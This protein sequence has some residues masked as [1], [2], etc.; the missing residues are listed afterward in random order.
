MPP[1]KATKTKKPKKVLKPKKASKHRKVTKLK[2]LTSKEERARAKLAA[3]DPSNPMLSLRPS[4]HIVGLK[5]LLAL[6]KDMIVR[7]LVF[8]GSKIHS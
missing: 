5:N 8:T 3:E 4:P 6:R 7:F 1:G 2:K